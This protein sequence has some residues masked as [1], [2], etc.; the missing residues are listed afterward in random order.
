[1]GRQGFKQSPSIENW[2]EVVSKLIEW[3]G[4]KAKVAVFP[5]GTSQYTQQPEQ[6]QT[7]AV[8]KAGSR[9]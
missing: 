6:E 1:M 8:V 4:L 9:T 7:Q 2:A 5:D 3:H